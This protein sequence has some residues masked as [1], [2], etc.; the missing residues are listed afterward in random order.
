MQA[1]PTPSALT[2]KSES[3]NLPPSSGSGS[4]PASLNLASADQ[5][6]TTQNTNQTTSPTAAP[7]TSPSIG[8]SAKLPSPTNFGFTTSQALMTVVTL[9]GA[10]LIVHS[11][12]RMNSKPKD[13]AKPKPTGDLSD[14][15][16]LRN[17]IYAKYPPPPRQPRPATKSP[18]PQLRLVDD[19]VA[20]P[21]NTAEIATLRQQIEQLSHEVAHL[22]S[23]VKDLEYSNRR[24][25][26]PVAAL[27]N[28]TATHEPP[29]PSAS[30]LIDHQNIYRLA[31]RG[32][33]A[34][35]IARTLG[36]HTGQVELILNLRRATGT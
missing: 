4:N 16:A 11:L 12:R 5:S 33:T 10:L 20:N 27:P 13:P 1:D 19:R 21:P 7:S 26:A 9:L 35:E 28:F 25:P 18:D 29:A 6:P 3:T 17:E 23:R 2:Q 15:T 32:M 22:Q 8:D 34:V 24:D 30:T 14:I 36:Q 31:D